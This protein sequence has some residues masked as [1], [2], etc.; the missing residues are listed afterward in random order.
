[1]KNFKN[2][3]VSK[4]K[5]FDPSNKY[6]SPSSSPYFPENRW[7]PLGSRINSIAKRG[8]SY[9]DIRNDIKPLDTLNSNFKSGQ[10][11]APNSS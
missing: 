11:S 9:N 8:K 10:N 7:K 6:T 2:F 4:L 5:Q 3:S 1:M